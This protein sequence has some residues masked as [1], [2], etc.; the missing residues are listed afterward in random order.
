MQYIKLELNEILEGGCRADFSG[1]DLSGADLSGAI[2]NKRHIK[3]IQLEKYDICYTSEV[4]TIGCQ[5]H[6][7]EQWFKFTD[8]EIDKMELG[9]LDWW[10][11]WKDIIK[12]IIEISQC[13]P[14]IWE[15]NK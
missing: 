2:G 3:S 10:N 11:K 14:T 1:A 5:S 8:K 12:N 13:E 4:M 9:A 15:M 6:D 7:I